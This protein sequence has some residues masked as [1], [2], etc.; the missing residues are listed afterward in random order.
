MLKV[1]RKTKKIINNNKSY[2]HGS[3]KTRYIN[4]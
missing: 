4:V 3:N 1:T 2:H